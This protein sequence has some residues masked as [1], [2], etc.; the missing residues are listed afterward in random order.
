M[1]STNERLASITGSFIRRAPLPTARGG[2]AGGVVSDNIYVVGGEDFSPS[3]TFPEVEIYDPEGDSWSAAPDLPT[4]RHGL[5]VEGV[6]DS[7]YVIG[8][9]PTAGLSVSPRNEALRAQ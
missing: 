3:R 1:K 7:I 8:G 6:R 5:A 2:T 9:G 4:P